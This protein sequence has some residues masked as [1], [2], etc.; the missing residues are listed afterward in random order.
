M[1]HKT[2]EG[3]LKAARAAMGPEAIQ[4]VDFDLHNTGAGWS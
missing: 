1:A 3:A 4:G 2:R